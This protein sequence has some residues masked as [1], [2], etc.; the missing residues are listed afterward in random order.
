MRK[1]FV[2]QVLAA[3][4]GGLCA[5]ALVA[6]LVALKFAGGK[7]K[8]RD[9]SWLVMDLYGSLPEYDAPGGVAGAVLGGGQTLQQALTGL[10][11]ARV[12]DRIAGVILK[13][14]ANFGAGAGKLQ[15]LRDAVHATRRAG[16]PVVGWADS[17]DRSTYWLAAACDTLLMPPTASMQLVGFSQSSLHL[18]NLLDRL[19]VKE[20]LHKIKDYKAAAE[21]LQRAD[22]SPEAIENRQWMMKERWEMFVADLQAD[23]GLSETRITELMQKALLTPAEAV[24][25]RLLDRLAY[26]DELE[27][28]LKGED[29]ERL[30]VVGLERYAQEKP[31]KLGLKGKKTVAVI[32][33]H[34]MLGGRESR[35]DPLL[36]P[37]IGHE[38]VCAQLRRARRDKDVAAIIFRVDSSGGE[39]VCS[40]LI[41]HEVEVTANVKPVVVSMV[42][43]AASGGYGVSYRATK[44]L[45]LPATTTGSIGSISG[46]LNIG[47]LLDKLGVTGSDVTL[48]PN[49]LMESDRRDYTAQEWAL[50][51][52][53]HW[54]EFN[55]WLADIAAH[56]GL[57]FAAAERLAHG[58]VWTGRQAKENRLIDD[59]GG[60]PRAIEVAKEL[61]RIP[62]GEKVTVAHY[63]EKKGLLESLT[64]DGG[65]DEGGDKS[66]ALEAV[67][68]AGW[69]TREALGET[70]RF[71]A[72]SSLML[73]PAWAGD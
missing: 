49:A 29:D 19:G 23:R 28:A 51:T 43:A 26:W 40:D 70:W 16:K 20:N 53:N 44:I 41:G 13:L 21:M 72:G 18:K 4:L 25:A 73:A 50:F 8:I 3:A 33:V 22:A 2:H 12:D 10:E 38:T 36:G 5:L 15:E 45:A 31:A 64:G 62:S 7:E 9:R 27:A 24:E 17:M 48:G 57:D 6:G 56:R 32:H 67:G 61:A 47:G 55:A 60:L 52:A 35:V 63:P 11:M 65:P 39:A 71:M 37:M 42:D 34:G 14:S 58:R 54:R 30:R 1:G 59:I 46:K 69:R 66:V 68:L